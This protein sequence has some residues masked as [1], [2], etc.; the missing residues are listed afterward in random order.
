[1]IVSNSTI[2]YLYINNIAVNFV[3]SINL[4]YKAMEK[5]TLIQVLD[6]L[7]IIYVRTEEYVSMNQEQRNEF[8]DCIEYLKIIVLKSDKIQ[9]ND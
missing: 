6:E 3:A 7:F 1:M 2:K 9:S 5:Q 4:K 8:C